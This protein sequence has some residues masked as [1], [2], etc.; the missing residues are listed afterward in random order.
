[1]KSSYNVAFSLDKYIDKVAKAETILYIG[2]V[3]AVNGLEI[4]SQGPRSVI[5]EICTIRIESLNTELLAEVVGLEIGR[6]HV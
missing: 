4:E 5:G 3:S 2:K 6:A 1:M